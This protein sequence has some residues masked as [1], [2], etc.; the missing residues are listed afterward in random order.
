MP[1]RDLGRV[2]CCTRGRGVSRS[3]GR[4][5]GGSNSRR[6]CGGAVCG[7]IW[8]GAEERGEFDEAGGRWLETLDELSDLL[9]GAGLFVSADTGP[10]HLA[11]QIGVRT[12]TLFGPTDPA[13][14][15]AIGPDARV[16]VGPDGTM[17]SVSWSAVREAILAMEMDTR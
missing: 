11:G 2:L 5:I 15:R 4:L 14:W 3:S 8:W 13:R 17:G 10:A 9:A 12:V 7:S 6:G 1:R 16:V